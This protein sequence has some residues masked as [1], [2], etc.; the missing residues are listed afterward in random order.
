[1]VRAGAPIARV[2][3]GCRGS[4]VDS[5]C[6]IP[7]RMTVKRGAPVLE[8]WGCTPVRKRSLARVPQSERVAVCD[9]SFGRS[10][11]TP[12]NDDE[13]VR[14]V[15]CLRGSVGDSTDTDV[16]CQ[17]RSEQVLRNF[18]RFG[19][20]SERPSPNE[21]VRGSNPLSSTGHEARPTC[22]NTGAGTGPTHRLSPLLSRAHP[23]AFRRSSPAGP[24]TSRRGAGTCSSWRSTRAPATPRR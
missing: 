14:D 1:V 19:K 22:G 12:R 21:K 17:P 23:P 18:H 13:F 9:G 6:P 24:R 4:L 15:P 11:S 8:A 5:P 2:R 10:A 7:P 3:A 16:G 20:M